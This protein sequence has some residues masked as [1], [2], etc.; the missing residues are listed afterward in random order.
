VFAL[1]LAPGCSTEVAQTAVLGPSDPLSCATPGGLHLPTGGAFGDGSE[2]P[3]LLVTDGY[4]A[5]EGPGLYVVARDAFRVYL[6]AELVVESL[7]AREG[8]FVPLT[9]LPGDNALSV[10]VSAES[11]TPAALVELHELDQ[12]LASDGSWK[13]STD[14]E[15]GYASAV[16]DDSSWPTATEYGGAGALPGCDPDAWFPAS[17]G[18]RWIGPAT[19]TG[20]TAVLRKVIRVA[21]VGY[22]EATTGGAGGPTTLVATWDELVAAAGDSDSPA[23]I[24]LGEGIHDFRDEREQLACPSVCTNDT[25]KTRYDVIGSDETCPEALVTRTRSDRRLSFAS[26]KTLVGLGRG[27][28]VRG[29]SFD[30]PGVENVVVRNLAVYDVNPELGEAGD[31]FTLSAPKR[32]WFDHVTIKWISD[33]F[34][35]VHAGA[36]DI[37][38]SWMRYDGV[39][40]GACRGFH[41]QAANVTDA[42]VTFHHCFFDHVES[43]A[44]RVEGASARVHV[45]DTLFADNGSYAV[46]SIC[47]SE[48]LMEANTFERVR[49]PTMRETCADETALG[50]IS[51]PSGSNHYEDVE[52]HQGGDG[53][54]PRDD[55]FDPPYT[56]PFDQNADVSL[57]ILL[58]AGAGGPWPLP[59]AL[60]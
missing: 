29:V 10:V 2:P 35:D 56:Y 15:N 55:V 5:G 58:R 59:L 26:N 33:G 18:T 34:S 45:V 1:L 30:L 43:H 17:T 52:G 22:G 38:F 14:P 50:K 21:P 36:E 46:G 51:A 39:T 11:G 40:P 48:V 13:V 16:F 9:L 4:G 20:R 25:T 23:V 53:M 6:N 12:D 27:A 19:G 7:A 47:G 32:V 37:T 54:E 31:A 44:P 8:V 28:L 60:D 42:L 3:S 24:V 49:T 57:R 41:T